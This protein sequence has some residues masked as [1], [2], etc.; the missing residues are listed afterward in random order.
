MGVGPDPWVWCVPRCRPDRAETGR[1]GEPVGIRWFAGPRRHAP[2]P[3]VLAP[4]VGSLSGMSGNDQLEA[5]LELA[6]DQGEDLAGRIQELARHDHYPALLAIAAEPT[7]ER[8]LACVPEEIRRGA[9]VHLDGA[10]RR[11]DLARAAARRNLDEATSALDEYD[12]NRARK[13]LDK[14][15]AAF[16]DPKTIDELTTL[17]A[18]YVAV[19]AEARELSSASAEIIAEVQPPESK[20]GFGCLGTAGLISLVLGTIGALLR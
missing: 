13:H 7:T 19:N 10:A 20:R 11:R 18:R 1:Q 9:Y 6:V 12:P 2:G 5:A 16:L 15:D 8:L 14:V 17:R 4:A 3:D